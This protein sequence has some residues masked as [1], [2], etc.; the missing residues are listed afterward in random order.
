MSKRGN[1]LLQ[2]QSFPPLIV[3]GVF[4]ESHFLSSWRFYADGQQLIWFIER[5][6][7]SSVFEVGTCH[8]SLFDSFLVQAL[9]VQSFN[10]D[11]HFFS[12]P[13]LFFSSS[14]SKA[15]GRQLHLLL[16]HGFRQTS[17]EV[18]VLLQLWRIVDKG[19]Y[20]L[21]EIKL[22]SDEHFFWEEFERF[23]AWGGSCDLLLVEVK[24]SGVHAGHKSAL[25]THLSQCLVANIFVIVDKPEIA[26]LDFLFRL[27]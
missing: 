10:I 8:E 22:F 20:L 25:W 16:L 12:S 11:K 2:N 24:Q 15:S 6:G 7:Q 5:E 21:S 23:W 9:A 17:T 18:V 3:L 26:L 13:S 14:T 27:V 19:L 4:V 1:D